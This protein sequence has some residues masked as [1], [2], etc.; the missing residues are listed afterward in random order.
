MGL[1]YGDLGT[2]VALLVDLATVQNDLVLAGVV[3]GILILH[4]VVLSIYDLFAAGGLGLKGV[5]L[6]L[7]FTRVLYIVFSPVFM[8]TSY[9]DAKRSVNT[10]KQSDI[11]YP[12][13][14]FYTLQYRRRHLLLLLRLSRAADKLFTT[15]LRHDMFCL[16]LQNRPRCKTVGSAS[17]INP[18]TLRSRDCSH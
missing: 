12:F 3:G 2:D 4:I 16:S 1:F 5:I 10:R 14:F 6:N 8:D 13:I 18:T 9:D 11:I 7:T 17:G 15:N